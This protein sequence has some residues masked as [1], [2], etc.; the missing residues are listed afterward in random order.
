MHVDGGLLGFLTSTVDCVAL[1]PLI[2]ASRCTRVHGQ[3]SC[4]L[5]ASN[6]LLFMYNHNN[7]KVVMQIMVREEFVACSQNGVCVEFD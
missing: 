6:G 4:Q 1:M 5:I 3:R 2:T 7:R